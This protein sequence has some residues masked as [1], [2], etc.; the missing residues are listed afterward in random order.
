[1][2]ANPC[3][4]SPY[5]S[6][7]AR[8]YAAGVV[9]VIATGN[10]A[11]PVFINSP[12]CALGAVAVGASFDGRYGLNGSN[13]SQVG[14]VG[15]VA[16]FTNLNGLIDLM[17][18]GLGVTAGGY[19][20]GTSMAA[21][22]VAGAIALIDELFSNSLDVQLIVDVLKMWSLPTSVGEVSYANLNL[23]PDQLRTF[24]IGVSLPLTFHQDPQR[25]LNTTPLTETFTVSPESN[26]QVGKVYLVD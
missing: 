25:T 10:N 6:F 7:F 24:E 26:F 13:C 5:A 11:D 14:D 15:D 2:I 4:N 3:Y 19:L 1:M 22:H 16:C 20:T 12:A 9:P 23:R 17:A 21:P 18:S 8:L